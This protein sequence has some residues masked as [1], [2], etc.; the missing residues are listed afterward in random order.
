[1]FHNLNSKYKQK[2][3]LNIRKLTADFNNYYIEPK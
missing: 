3:Q 1:M 2:Q